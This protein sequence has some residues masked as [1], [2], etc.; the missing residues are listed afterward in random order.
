[1][2][3]E[4]LQSPPPLDAPNLIRKS[5][6]N[7][8][9]AIPF[10]QKLAY[11]TPHHQ[12]W[13]F[14]LADADNH[15]LKSWLQGPNGLLE[16]FEKVS[17]RAGP[18]GVHIPNSNPPGEQGRS[19]RVGMSIPSAY[20]VPSSVHGSGPSISRLLPTYPS[21]DHSPDV[22]RRKKVTTLAPWELSPAILNPRHLVTEQL[23]PSTIQIAYPHDSSGRCSCSHDV[24]STL[25]AH[26]SIKGHRPNR[27]KDPNHHA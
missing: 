9:F 15:L 24:L 14:S 5:A 18:F 20:S 12:S 16:Q 26:W 19:D 11:L 13:C 1:M 6:S 8:L 4:A 25:G 10:L 27:S 23:T 21:V 3:I 22:L 2:P 7:P 17:L